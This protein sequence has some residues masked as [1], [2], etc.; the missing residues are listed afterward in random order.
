MPAKEEEHAHQ[1]QGIVREERNER[2]QRQN[3]QDSRQK[4]QQPDGGAAH[5]CRMAPLFQRV[6]I[7]VRMALA[8]GLGFGVDQGSL[9]VALNF[10]SIAHQKDREDDIHHQENRQAQP[11]AR[12][13]RQSSQFLRYT[14]GKG[15]GDGN[16]EAHVGSQDAHAQPDQGIP[17]KVISQGYNQ[18]NKGNDLFNNTEE[19]PQAHK[20]EGNDHQQQ[21]F[22]PAK[23]FHN[24]RQAGLEQTT[25]IQ[26][27]K[28]RTDHEQKDEDGDN[29]QAVRSPQHF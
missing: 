3:K 18:R 24:A 29:D 13:K 12:K 7:E 23:G 10:P 16:R 25:M 8:F 1:G 26:H 20:K 28:S 9:G 19:C 6:D 2:P 4:S 15:V 5:A 27:G 11:G 14:N 21:V 22:A 17:A